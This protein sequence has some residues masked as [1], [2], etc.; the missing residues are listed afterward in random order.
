MSSHKIVL[1][2]LAKE[3]FS[4]ILW[5]TWQR[6]G[7]SQRDRYA[8]KLDAALKNLS[9][10]PNLG[11]PRDD[12]FRG[13]HVLNVEKHS[14]FYRITGNNTLEIIRILSTRMNVHRRIFDV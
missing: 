8:E 6:W 13:C 9:H 12:L 10:F 1:S 5:Y 2:A 14:F 3:D 11:M 4:D 7:E